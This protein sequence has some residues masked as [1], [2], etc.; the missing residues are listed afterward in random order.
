MNLGLYKLQYDEKDNDKTWK[1]NLSKNLMGR[2]NMLMREI[3]IELGRGFGLRI[4]R[5]D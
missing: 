3:V 2:L 1:R 4:S 5:R